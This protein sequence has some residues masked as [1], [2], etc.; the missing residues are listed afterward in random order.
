MEKPKSVTKVEKKPGSSNL[1]LKSVA[2]K[3]A[4]SSNG[5]P[6][7]A[8]PNGEIDVLGV[9][10]SHPDRLIF[11]DPPVTKGELAGF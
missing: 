10:I 4:T 6:R 5:A 7:G 8:T 2:S 9:R 11:R 3:K 1:A